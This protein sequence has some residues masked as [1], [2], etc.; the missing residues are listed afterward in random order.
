[1][2]ASATAGGFRD[3]AEK[4]L[5]PEIRMPA[6]EVV[7]LCRIAACSLAAKFPDLEI[8]VED[9][10]A[11]LSLVRGRIK[12]FGIAHTVGQLAFMYCGPVLRHPAESL[13]MNRLLSSD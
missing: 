9:H 5:V 7:S 1:M 12:R 3:H 4:A 2:I 6:D 13:K 10:V 8:I 11:R